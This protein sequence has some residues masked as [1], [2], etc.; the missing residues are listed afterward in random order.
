MFHENRPR[1]NLEKSTLDIFLDVFSFGILILALLYTILNYS[2]LPE[3]VPM[4]FN[5]SGEIT[6]YDSKDMIWVFFA[7]G[8]P[9]IY[10]IFYL[11]KFPHI[12]NYPQKIT[13]ENTK[14]MY[15]DA[16][17]MLRFLNV[18]IALLLAIISF[19]I[20][21]VSLNQSKSITQTANYL[22]MGIVILMTIGPLIYVVLNLRKQKN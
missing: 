19:E 20:V 12:F 13:A 9:T 16:T 4:H 11:N 18:S 22:I 3:L 8:F 5:H 7:I 2:A 6:R 10:G 15:S 1:I 14:K 21:Q 17:R